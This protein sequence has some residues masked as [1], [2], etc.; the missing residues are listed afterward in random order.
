VLFRITVKHSLQIIFSTYLTINQLHFQK[1]CSNESANY[2]CSHTGGGPVVGGAN[3]G[4]PNWS[5]LNGGR[6]TKFGG[7]R[8]SGGGGP[9][10]RPKAASSIHKTH[11]LWSSVIILDSHSVSISI[12]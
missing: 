5:K 7:G 6:S 1:R 4:R 9:N 10:G 12:Q 2:L 3:K 11:S 8:L